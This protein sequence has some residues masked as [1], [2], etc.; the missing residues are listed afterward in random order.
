MKAP[1]TFPYGDY[2]SARKKEID[3]CININL[4]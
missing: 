4:T 2:D 3:C 1:I